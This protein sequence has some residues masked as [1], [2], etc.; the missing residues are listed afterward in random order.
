MVAVVL[1]PY[2]PFTFVAFVRVCACL[3][4]LISLLSQVVVVFVGV[5]CDE[6]SGNTQM[7]HSQIVVLIASSLTFGL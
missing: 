2:L 4:R 3:L 1:F 7:A 6:P 5:V